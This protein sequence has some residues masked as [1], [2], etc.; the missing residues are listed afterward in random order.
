[1]P[2]PRLEPKDFRTLS[3]IVPVYNERSTVAEIIRRARAAQV[4]LVIDLIVVDDAS[5][6]G[7]DKVLGALADSTV[8]VLSHQENRGKGASI[9]TALEYARGDLLLIQ[10]ADLEYDPDDWPRM[11]EPILK[12][13]AAV[14]YGSRFTGERK[15]MLMLHWMGNRLLSLVTNVLYSSTLSDM[16]TCYKL[17]DRRVLEGMVLLSDRF[18]FEPEVTAKVLRRGYRI[19]EVPIS[20]AGR[21]VHEGKKITWR[22]GIGA[23]RALVRFRFTKAY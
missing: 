4:P 11:L 10:D 3:V 17:F 13:K 12:H 8:R 7:T 1:M 22:D 19:Y 18:E 20:Y 16:E 9:R 21:E 15:N 23:L 14:V 6:D 2:E 5:T